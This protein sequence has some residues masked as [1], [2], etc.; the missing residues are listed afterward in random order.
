MENL[1]FEAVVGVVRHFSDDF[2]S[3]DRVEIFGRIRFQ[4]RQI[5]VEQ[6]PVLRHPLDGFQHVVLQRQLLAPI[7]H[8][9]LLERFGERRI[10]LDALAQEGGLAGVIA[11]VGRVQFQEGAL[12]HDDIGDAR[13]RR[14][15]PHPQFEIGQQVLIEAAQV[16]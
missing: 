9:E 10:L 7:R 5:V 4:I 1:D 3:G 14:P 12:A 16:R 11:D 15:I 6:E 13:I 2:Q 8:F